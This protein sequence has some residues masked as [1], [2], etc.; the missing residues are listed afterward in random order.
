MFFS[1]LYYPTQLMP[2]A[3]KDI[4][5]I[6]PLGAAA[7]A[8]QDTVTGDGRHRRHHLGQPE[9]AAPWAYDRLSRARP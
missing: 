7:E 1:G 6:T 2:A 4:A 3:L 9:H 8:I 5:H